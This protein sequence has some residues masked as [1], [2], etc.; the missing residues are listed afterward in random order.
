M[1][2]LPSSGLS[3]I[4]KDIWSWRDLRIALFGCGMLIMGTVLMYS[5]AMVPLLLVVI[6]PLMVLTRHSLLLDLWFCFFFFCISLS[7]YGKFNICHL[8]RQNN[9]YWFWRCY[10]ENMESKKWWKHS[11]YKRYSSGIQFEMSLLRPNLNIRFQ[12]TVNLIDLR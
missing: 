3:G 12:Q 6:L 8:P 9:M 10:L 7:V 11:C 4:Q 2:L 5:Q 1:D